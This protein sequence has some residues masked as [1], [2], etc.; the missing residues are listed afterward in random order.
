MEDR[1]SRQELSRKRRRVAPT[2]VNSPQHIDDVTQRS[3]P[4]VATQEEVEDDIPSDAMAALLFLKSQFPSIPGVR[5]QF[6]MYGECRLRA[7]HSW[8]FYN[9]YLFCFTFSMQVAPFV[10]QSHLYTLMKDRTSIDKE[11]NV[12]RQSNQV[13][14][15]KL[16]CQLQGFN[17]YAVMLTKDYCQLIETFKDRVNQPTVFDWF[18]ERV[19]PKYS[20]VVISKDNLAT[21]LT[22]A[23]PGSH[24]NTVERCV[25]VLLQ[26]C[27][28]TIYTH[29]SKAA[30]SEQ[31]SYLFSIPN[32]G[33]AIRGIGAGRK[34]LLNIFRRRK[35]PEILEADLVLERRRVGKKSYSLKSSPLGISWHVR[36]LLAHG[37]LV[38]RQSSMGPV[39]CEVKQST[40]EKGKAIL[41]DK[42][43]SNA[44][45]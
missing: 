21:L 8:D 26:S 5:V 41:K 44:S 1:K 45:G 35:P 43:C 12:L 24:L 34:E 6:P 9:C 27:C 28:L 20:D 37:L 19:L 31:T 30:Y 7:F 32:A 16:P 38:R 4:Q 10:L 11:L 22:A 15:F 18:C 36:D 23:V 2:A 3:R 33:K 29:G 17:D 39:L 25:D 13:R 42:K 14:F 40:R